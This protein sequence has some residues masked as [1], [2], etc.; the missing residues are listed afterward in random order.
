MSRQFAPMNCETTKLRAALNDAGLSMAVCYAR[1]TER[2]AGDGRK[3][4]CDEWT[5]RIESK[6]GGGRSYMYLFPF[7]TGLGHRKSRLTPPKGFR[8]GVDSDTFGRFTPRPVAPSADCVLHSLFLDRMAARMSFRDWCADYGYD[9]DSLRALRLYQDCCNIDSELQRLRIPADKWAA[10]F[11][12]VDA[13]ERG[14]LTE[15]GE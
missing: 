9:D 3:W 8:P 11:E 5:V 4:A 12:I 15:E 14:E 6:H 1:E 7:Y 2:D 10:L 13:H